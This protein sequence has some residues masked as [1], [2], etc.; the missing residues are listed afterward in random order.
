MFSQTPLRQRLHLKAHRAPTTPHRS[1][2]TTEPTFLLASLTLTISTTTYSTSLASGT[3]ATKSNTSRA[4]IPDTVIT[5]M[6]TRQQNYQQHIP[7]TNPAL[8]PFDKIGANDKATNPPRLLDTATLTS[9]LHHT[10]QDD[11]LNSDHLP[12]RDG[13][14]SSTWICPVEHNQEKRD[15]SH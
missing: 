15:P 14:R 3:L 12:Q 7:L 1:Q 4:G 9:T 11:R 2:G 8:N 5:N 6:S 10:P 13:P